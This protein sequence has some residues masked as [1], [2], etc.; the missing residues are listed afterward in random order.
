V[1]NKK[2]RQ[3]HGAYVSEL[4]NSF[5][6]QMEKGTLTADDLPR[7]A[8][9]DPDIGRRAAALRLLRSVESPDMSDFEPVLDGQQSLRELRAAGISTAAV[10]KCKTKRRT[11]KRGEEEV[12]EVERELELRDTSLVEHQD[13]MDRTEGKPLPAGIA[14]GGNVQIVVNVTA[15]GAPQPVEVTLEDVP[16]M[17]ELIDPPVDRGSGD[18]AGEG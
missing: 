10:K 4:V 2:G 9:K 3:S 15:L 6:L 18:A 12:V 7:I 5:S 17:P 11:I 8:K 14:G 13:L 16:Q 1:L